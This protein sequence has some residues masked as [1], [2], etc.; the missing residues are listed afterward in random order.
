ML[1]GDV[2][3]MGAHKFGTRAALVFNDEEIS[4]AELHARCK[5]LANALLALAAPGDRV[6]ILSQNRP[7]FVDAYFGV[8]MAGMALT[9]LNYRLA[10]RELSRIIADAEASVLLVEDAYAETIAGIRDELDSVRT[11]VLIGAPEA[12]TDVT[13]VHYDELLAA[14]PDTDPAVAVSEQDMA[15][16]IYTS[17]TTGMPKG[18]M[19][20]HRSLLAALASW[21]IHSSNSVAQD[22]SLMMFPLCHIAGVGVVGNVLMGVTLVLRRAYEPLDA[23]TMI[24]RYGVTATSFAPTMLSMLLQHPKIDEFS[25]GSLRTIAYGGSSMPVETLRRV[26]ARFP[27]ADF[28]QGFGMT[29]LS[30]NV[31]YFDPASHRLAATD[32][33]ELL[34]AAGRTMALSRIR[35]VDDEMRDVAAGDVGEIVVRGDQVMLGYWRRP[36]ANEEAF[37]GGWFHTGDMGRSDVDG[38]VAIVDRKKDMIVTGGENVYSKEVEDVVYTV[39]GVAEAS[40]IGLPDPHWGE[41]VAAV[42]VVA[43]G[44]TVTEGDIIAACRA[45]LAGYKKPKRVFFVEELPRNA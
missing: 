15:W 12:G 34:V 22:V 9:F 13:D 37:A 27:D 16:I 43:P 41:N 39:A 21:M 23:M 17:G 31:L 7:E 29:E 25:L 8:P 24:D 44:A 11:V 20:S 38:Y 2:V 33:P 14:A 3:A 42:V 45:N 40:V 26:M 28:V 30:G 18:A 4:F 6:A 19:L 5:R 1:L 36:E 10:P 35:L 32:R